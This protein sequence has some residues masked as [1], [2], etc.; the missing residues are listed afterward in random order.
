PCKGDAKSAT[1]TQVF[2][3]R[4]GLL[5]KNK[6]RSPILLGFGEDI[7]ALLSFTGQQ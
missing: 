4:G 7:Y 1:R 5:L 6:P 3:I 2:S